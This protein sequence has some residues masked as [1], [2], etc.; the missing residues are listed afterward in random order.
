MSSRSVK[1]VG[2]PVASPF[3]LELALDLIVGRHQERLDVR[4]TFGQAL[5][6]D[7]ENGFFRLIDRAC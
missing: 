7:F 4:E 2:V 1:P 5:G 6:A 3:A